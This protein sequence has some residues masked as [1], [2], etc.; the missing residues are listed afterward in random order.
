M[1]RALSFALVGAAV[2]GCKPTVDT[3]DFEAR[4]HKRI[5]ELGLP[6]GKVTCPTHVEVKPGAL[7]TC[8]V[9]IA[10]KPY[11]LDVTIIDAKGSGDTEI[12]LTTQWRGGSAIVGTKLAPVLEAA[13]TKTL[14]IPVKVDCGAPLRFIDPKHQ[15]RCDLTAGAAK[16]GLLTT[17]DAKDE[18]TDWK[19]DP[20]TLLKSKLEEILT[21]SVR[22]KTAADATVTCGSEPMV[23]RPADGIVH[24]AITA[25]GKAG[26]IA[27]V[28]DEALD[29]QRWDVE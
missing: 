26:K 20:P 7:F 18:P 16:Y 2:V 13:M 22:E 21:P 10:A 24:C 14:G 9:E 29:V 11:D 3:Q 17:F 19:L 27:V 12:N 6:P 25:G 23:A 28:V 8:A 1:K 15:L 4:I 5:A